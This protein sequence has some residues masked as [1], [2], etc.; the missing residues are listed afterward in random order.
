MASLAPPPTRPAVAPTLTVPAPPTSVWRRPVFWFGALLALSLVLRLWLWWRAEGFEQGDPIEYVNIAYRIAFGIG[1]PWWDLRPLLLS[2]IYVPVLLLGQFWPD[3]TGEAQV[4]LLRLVAVGFATGM[5]VVVFLIGRRLAGAAGGLFAAF[6]VAVNP[7]LNELAVSTYAEVPSTFFILVSIWLLAASG[8]PGELPGWRRSVLAGVA[9]GVACMIRYQAIAFVPAIVAW[10]LARSLAS[11]RVRPGRRIISVLGP[12]SPLSAL[13]LGLLV[14]T[15]AQAAIELVAYGR[16]FHSLIVSFDYNVSSGLAPVEFGSEPFTWY[17]VQIP[18]WLGI[19]AAAL[20]VVG[21]RRVYRGPRRAEWALVALAAAAMLLF[22]SALPHK[23]LRF[24][25]QIIPMVALL[26]GAGAVQVAALAAVR[27]PTDARVSRAVSLAILAAVAGGPS[28]VASLRLDVASNVSYVDGPKQAAS[29][30]PGGTMGTIP[31]LV[32]RPYAGTRLALERM[33]RRI[34]NDRD[35]VTRTVEESDFLLFPEFW[36]LEDPFVRRL[37]D[38]RYRTI[39]AYDN[40][41]VLLQNK[42]L[43]EPQERRPRN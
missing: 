13:C 17:L 31:W 19:P 24:M 6:L 22:L 21:L 43:D 42:R 35:H 5:L 26:A 32:P 34:W 20:A 12:A 18:Q 30:K 29:I 23:E 25:V 11:H 10:E 7:V 1:I 28:L 39:A 9:L 40:G 3:P 15:A 14:A 33:D 38:N 8:L 36:L 27:L 37:V 2:L 41:V 4:K 16:P